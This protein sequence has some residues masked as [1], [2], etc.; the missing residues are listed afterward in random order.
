MAAKPR[1]ML[2]LSHDELRA[3]E[4]WRHTYRWPSRA[5]AIR[6]M[7]AAADQQRI[8][9]DARPAPDPSRVGSKPEAE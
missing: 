3:V 4:D 6:S 9:D 2:E 8:R 1:F 5:A 7:I